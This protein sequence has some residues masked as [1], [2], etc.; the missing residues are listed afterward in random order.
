MRI[1]LFGGTFNPI[2]RCHL[3]IAA[4]TR[5][6][7][8]LDRIVF[9]PS[10]DPPHKPWQ[11]LA[12]ARHRMEMLRRAITGEPAFGI[13]DI[14]VRRPSKSYSI[15]TIQALR[16]EYGPE[17]ELFFI[18]G[19]DAFLEFPGWRE[20]SR[21]LE[22]CHFVVVSRPGATFRSLASIPLLP[23]VEEP[24]LAALDARRD[25]RADIPLSGATRLILLSL[26]P[27]DASASLVRERLRKRE[28]VANLLPASVESYIMQHRLYQEEPDHTGA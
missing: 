17:A 20:P 7:L 5:Q 16:G 24:L 11:S 15:E 6:R 3:T 23:K 9:I 18:L 22:A 12:S 21:L 27:C 10:G 26:P 4:Q 25:E 28:S 8:G 13:S 1:G 2:H 19:L 14:E